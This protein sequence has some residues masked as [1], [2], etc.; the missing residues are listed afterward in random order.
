M[1]VSMTK[2]MPG[3]PSSRPFNAVLQVVESQGFA[4]VC[5]VSAHNITLFALL[6]RADQVP[7]TKPKIGA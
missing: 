4:K 3:Q 2:K 7:Q 1:P 6:D 5:Q